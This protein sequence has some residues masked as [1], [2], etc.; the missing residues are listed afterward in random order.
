[1]KP[2]HN[3]RAKVDTNNR[4]AK[5]KKTNIKKQKVEKENLTEEFLL[6]SGVPEGKKP[7]GNYDST[8]I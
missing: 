7:L 4:P 2:K 3:I 5:K 6:D 8:N 1:L